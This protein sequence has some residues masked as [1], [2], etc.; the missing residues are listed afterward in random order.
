MNGQ[1]YM[2]KFGVAMG[3]KLVSALA[4]LFLH[5]VEQDYLASVAVWSTN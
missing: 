2:Q 3:T 1:H 4:T 5:Y